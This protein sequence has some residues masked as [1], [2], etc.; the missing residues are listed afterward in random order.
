MIKP[1][2]CLNRYLCFVHPPFLCFSAW[3]NAAYIYPSLCM[4]LLIHQTCFLDFLHKSLI[5]DFNYLKSLPYFKI[6]DIHLPFFS[7]V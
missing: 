1:I 5:H 3:L 4:F 6:V 2:I 7:T